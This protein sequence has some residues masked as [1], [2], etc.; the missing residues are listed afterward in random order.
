[1]TLSARSPYPPIS[2]YALIGDCHTAALVSRAGSI[3]WCCVPRFD[4]GSCFGRLLDWE[5]GGC[6]SISPEGDDFSTF[7]RY[8]DGTLVLETIL[9]TSGGEARL[10]DCFAMR[11][12]G[13]LDPYHQLLRVAEGVRGRV[14]LR[15]HVAPRFEYGA[16]RPWMRHEGIRLFSAIGGDDALVIYCDADLRLEG[17]HDLTA[18]FSVRAGERVRTAITYTDPAQLDRDRPTVPEDREL[19]RRLDATLAWWRGWSA[20]AR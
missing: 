17:R 16:V 11:E 3:D 2:D 6:C 1:M 14:D 12:G 5:Q 9:P 19:D 15:L 10:L 7:R 18:R 13:K 20:Q 4:D 8:V